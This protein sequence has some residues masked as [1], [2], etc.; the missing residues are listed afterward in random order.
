MSNTR[1][2]CRQA[3]IITTI[4]IIIIII[5]TITII[6]TIII[7]TIIIITIIII[8]IIIIIIKKRALLTCP[9]VQEDHPVRASH[10][11]PGGRCKAG[12]GEAANYLRHWEPSPHQWRLALR[13]AQVTVAGSEGNSGNALFQTLCSKKSGDRGGCVL[14]R[15]CSEN[16]VFWNR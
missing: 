2:S 10:R 16:A 8:T 4:I 9:E 13:P 7:I 6:T 1:K 12:P 14:E 11:P 5:T 15:Q 3:A